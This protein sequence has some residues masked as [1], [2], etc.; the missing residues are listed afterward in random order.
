MVLRFSEGGR[1]AGD[2]APV[3]LTIFHALC[4]DPEQAASWFDPAIDQRHPFVPMLLLTR[5]YLPVLRASSRWPML[6]RRL[7]LSETS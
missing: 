6:A 4:N 7:N 3:A 1:S 2:D 5:P